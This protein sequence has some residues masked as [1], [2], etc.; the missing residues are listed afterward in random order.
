MEMKVEVESNIEEYLE[1]ITQI[2]NT[3]KELETLI[4]KANEFTVEVSAG[5][6]TEI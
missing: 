4:N 5:D 6:I 1:I 2:K 3:A